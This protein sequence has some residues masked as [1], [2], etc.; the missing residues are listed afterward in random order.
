MKINKRALGFILARKNMN[1]DEIN[2]DGFSEDEQKEILENLGDAYITKNDIDKAFRSF[3]KAGVDKDRIIKGANE[4]LEK[5][6]I[7]GA[8]EVYEKMKIKPDR[9]LLIE[10]GEK[11][12]EGT[13]TTIDDM[14][15]LEI[16]MHLFDLAEYK[17]GLTKLG[18][19]FMSY[20]DMYNP[21]QRDLR[22]ALIAYKKS[23]EKSKILLVG[24]KALER[25]VYSIVIEAFKSSD[26]KRLVE[27]ADECILEGRPLS[28]ATKLYEA[29]EVK[30]DEDKLIEIGDRY[31]E[32]GHRKEAIEA[33]E[34][35]GK[36]EE[37]DKVG[38]SYLDA[39]RAKYKKAA[40]IFER[41]KNEKMIKFL[42]N[43]N[44]I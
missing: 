41:T 27:I 39:P 37:L 12:L 38:F 40:E 32:S 5:L 20:D 9:D 44:F 26:K 2:L 25:R 14:E 42:K 23:G 4:A 28:V 43:N 35:S 16:V 36:I 33:Y 3:E 6:W 29:A 11:L 30:V 19:M 7:E 22:N 17:D 1:P 13:R 18:D 15:T 24:E 21:Y 10:T 34:K 31:I 8:L